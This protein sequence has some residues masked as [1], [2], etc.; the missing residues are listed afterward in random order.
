[1]DSDGFVRDVEER[2]LPMAPIIEYAIR[3][4]LTDVGA[5][6]SS[7]T[8]VQAMKFIEKMTEA[9]DLFAGPTEAREARMFMLK[10]LRRRAPEFFAD[11]S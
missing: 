4:Q 9:L 8:P 5:S 3:K 6:R 1:M 11:G 7:L 2:L 10:A